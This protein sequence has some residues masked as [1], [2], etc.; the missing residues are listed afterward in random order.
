MCVLRHP[1]LLYHLTEEGHC[2]PKLFQHT[3][4]C[5]LVLRWKRGRELVHCCTKN[6]RPLL[7]AA[8]HGRTQLVDELLQAGADVHAC[9]E[10]GKTPLHVASESRHG[11]ICCQLINSGAK[12]DATMSLFPSLKKAIVHG[13]IDLLDRLLH[14]GVSV[15]EAGDGGL[16]AL[17]EAACRHVD[18]V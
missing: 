6:S 14:H 15:N 18:Q 13:G 12:V 16:T 17:H 8:K 11:D 10:S 1:I 7:L 5:L 2:C 9:N 3:I 4:V